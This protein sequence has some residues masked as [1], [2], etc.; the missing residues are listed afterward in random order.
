MQ[1]VTAGTIQSQTTTLI[2]NKTPEQKTSTR[3]TAG[4]TKK[5]GTLDFPQDIVNLS[6]SAAVSQSSLDSKKP[7]AVVSNA[8]KDALLK[9]SSGKISFSTYA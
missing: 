5:T 1:P 3:T 8:E 6:T 2:R 7:S 4:E 9:T